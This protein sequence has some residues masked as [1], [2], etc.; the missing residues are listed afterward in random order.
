M[1]TLEPQEPFGISI[2]NPFRLWDELLFGEH[3]TREVVSCVWGK[4]FSKVD[5]YGKI[6]KWGCLLAPP[7]VFYWEA[8][9]YKILALKNMKSQKFSLPNAAIYVYCIGVMRNWCH[10]LHYPFIAPIG[11]IFSHLLFIFLK[12]SHLLFIVLFLSFLSFFFFFWVLIDGWGSRAFTRDRIFRELIALAIGW[13]LS[14]KHKRQVFGVGLC[15]I[16]GKYHWVGPVD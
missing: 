9:L 16:Q 13:I 4:L 10:L 15:E 2:Q 7:S 14:W 1:D 3:S 8:Y 12:V 11:I 5:L 6:N